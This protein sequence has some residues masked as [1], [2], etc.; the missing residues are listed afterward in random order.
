MGWRGAVS[1][2]DAA[3]KQQEFADEGDASPNEH[4][5]QNAFSHGL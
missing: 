5:E 3:D 4:A 2:P 1:D